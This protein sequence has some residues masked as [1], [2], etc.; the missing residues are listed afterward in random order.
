MGRAGSHSDLPTPRDP[1]AHRADADLLLVAGEGQFTSHELA[2]RGAVVI[3]RGEDCDVHIDHRS[4]SRRHAALRPGPPATVQDLGSTNGTLIAG[5]VHH[6]G[7]PVE[8]AAGDAF[9][10]GPFSFVIVGRSMTGSSTSLG[11]H[12]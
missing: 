6:G 4:L 11:G 5:T 9:R 1:H 12:D 10:T 2:G 7:D 8:L 3:G